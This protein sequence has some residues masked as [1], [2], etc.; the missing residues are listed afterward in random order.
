MAEN[1]NGLL[2]RIR[3][4]FG[5]QEN[6]EERSFANVHM[7]ASFPFVPTTTGFSLSEDGALAVSAV[8]AC[9]NK[10]SSTIASMD[11]HLYERDRDGKIML[12][13]HPSL[14]LVSQAPSEYWNPFQFFQHL[15]SDA[16]I[17]GCGYAEIKRNGAGDPV[18]LE[19]LSPTKVKMKY[20]DGRRMYIHE[21]HTD[22]YYNE[23]L[24][25]VECFR[26]LSP[27]REHMENISLGYAAQMYGSSFFGSGG[28][29]SGVLHT[30]KILTEEQYNRL[31][32]TWDAKYHGMNAAH[33]T[34]VLEAGL[35]Y[36]RVGIPPDQC[37]FLETRKYQVEEVCRIFNVPTS[38]VQMDA[39][40]KYSNQEQQDLFFAKHTI[41]PWL[42]NIEQE[43]NK[44]LLKKSERGKRMFKFNMMSLMRGDMQA[45]ANYYQTLLMSG[46]FSVNEVRAM[47]DK[48]KV[49]EGDQHLV[50]INQIPLDSMQSYAQSITNSHNQ[51]SDG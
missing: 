47:E 3:K 13:A 9:V 1:R 34:A 21:D 8:Y 2:A 42:K 12:D 32:Q 30:D 22:A 23:D 48:N 37:Q 7:G 5:G 10:I 46:V 29:M 51:N 33:S 31:M 38:M 27:I 50:Q 26:G 6:T 17:H 18:S 44:K 39:N 28:N 20:I 41:A 24:L 16:L 35:R 25:V 36:E 15:V 43:L 19:L 49:P 40:V 4:A 11:L 14:Y 45:R